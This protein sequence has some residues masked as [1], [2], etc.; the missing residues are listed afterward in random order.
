MATNTKPSA[1]ERIK[2]FA[3]APGRWVGEQVGN[4]AYG[5]GY[6]ADGQVTGRPLGTNSI[7]H[8]AAT[9]FANGVTPSKPEHQVPNFMG[10][11]GEFLTG[12]DIAEGGPVSAPT[13]PAVAPNLPPTNTQTS[14][15]PQAGQ[16]AGGGTPAFDPTSIPQGA[17]GSPQRNYY[18]WAQSGQ[19]MTPERR[20]QA[21]ALAAS[22]GTTFDPATGYARPEQFAT[23]P[24]EPIS[25]FGGYSL[26]DGSYQVTRHVRDGVERGRDLFEQ[27]NW[28]SDG[29]LVADTINDFADMLSKENGTPMTGMRPIDPN[30]GEPLSQGVIDA[31]ARAG[32]ELPMAS[33]PATVAPNDPIRSAS[34]LTGF[35]PA[36]EGQSLSDYMAGRDDPAQ[37]TV[38]ATDYQG[39]LRRFDS[40]AAVAAN[41][42][43][44]RANYEAASEA[45]S[46]G[47]TFRRDD[48]SYATAPSTFNRAVSDAERRGEL[49]FSDYVDMA[50]GDRRAARALQV[51]AR[52]DLDPVSRQD[53]QFEQQLELTDY[54]AD[55][56]RDNAQFRADLTREATDHRARV[57]REASDQD[58]INQANA[59]RQSQG[60]EPIADPA[61]ARTEIF[62]IARDRIT[63]QEKALET[64]LA[65]IESLQQRANE[66]AY[67]DEL[68][69][70]PDLAEQVNSFRQ[71][72]PDMT[73]GQ[74]LTYIA[75]TQGNKFSETA[76]GVVERA[77][78]TA[79]AMLQDDPNS[80]FNVMQRQANKIYQ[81]LVSEARETPGVST[82][83]GIPQVEP[84]RPS[85]T[86]EQMA[87]VQRIIAESMQG[88]Q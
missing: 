35:T 15:N 28:S 67:A 86:P 7:P 82:S 29:E 74:A 6:A 17:E 40:P 45:R 87:E 3:L 43:Q 20:T 4:Q 32:L 73:T 48:S 61:Q 41:L 44:G 84:M 50:G 5:T 49:P 78:S 2:N 83:M 37:S 39:R 76:A 34:D 12:M 57:I 53:A 75:N 79:M 64:S 59:I 1:L 31:A 70:A 24:E 38:Q 33:V 60:Q 62:Q 16:P 63:M 18:D 55:L 25:E 66:Q 77:P 11:A 69:A 21:E 9:W 56:E 80:D 14:A 47:I 51:Q 22:V 68:A 27:D 46:D 30:T 13:P 72:F 71:Q 26:P 52:N 23:A 88:R 19:A 54:R 65:N 10:Y 58:V 81:G 36:Y 85:F 42:G 8:A